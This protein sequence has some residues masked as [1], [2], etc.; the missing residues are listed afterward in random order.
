MKKNPIEMI[1]KAGQ[2]GEPTFTLR[3]KDKFSTVVIQHYIS[4][5]ELYPESTNQEHVAGVKE[6]HQEFLTWREQNEDKIKIPD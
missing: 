2:N 4:L 6:I 1:Q 5:L 3:A